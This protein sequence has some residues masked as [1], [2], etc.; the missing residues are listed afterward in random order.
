MLHPR[1]EKSVGPAEQG[2]VENISPTAF[3]KTYC[4]L[5]FGINRTLVW[6][7]RA[8]KINPG[9]VLSRVSGRYD[10]S[11]YVICLR[12]MLKT[13]IRNSMATKQIWSISWVYV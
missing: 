4:R 12:K 2:V 6:S 5:E 9:G 11:D 10:I 3:P 13:S 1:Q 8:L 7:E